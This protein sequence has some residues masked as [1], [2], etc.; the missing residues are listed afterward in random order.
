M[1]KNNVKVSKIF[2]FDSGHRLSNYQG[3][4]FALHGHTYKLEVF[5]EGPINQEGMVVDFGDL[6]KIVNEKIV[7]KFDHKTILFSGD[8]LNNQI[9][10]TMPTDWF[11]AVDYN[12]TAE[13]MLTDINRILTDF[14]FDSKVGFNI[15]QL[16]L[17]ET[18][19]SCAIINNKKTNE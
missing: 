8:E 7:K 10:R 16:I 4:C 11:V 2:Y 6:K 1:E 17:W 9:M 12:P 18:P 3:K 15:F 13:N 14:L 5:V 19:T